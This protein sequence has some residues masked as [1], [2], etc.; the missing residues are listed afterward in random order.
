LWPCTKRDKCSGKKRILRPKLAPMKV[1]PPVGECA[2]FLQRALRGTRERSLDGGAP[3]MPA[4]RTL[5]RA[6][7]R[8]LF[9]RASVRLCGCVDS[10]RSDPKT[11]PIPD[12]FGPG[13]LCSRAATFR[14]LRRQT[15]PFRPPD[16]RR[17]RIETQPFRSPGKQCVGAVPTSTELFSRIGIQTVKLLKE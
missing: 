10:R 7:R 13:D 14:Y 3:F 1:G 11:S 2:P 6:A 9:P 15:R 17:E 8:G 4:S 5:D 16:L 12:V